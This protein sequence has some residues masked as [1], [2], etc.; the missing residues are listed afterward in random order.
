MRG[1]YQRLP[2][3]AGHL[4]AGPRLSP[5]MGGMSET[6]R[7]VLLAKPRGYCAGVDRA[8]QAVE[9][10]LTRF[11]APVYVR[12]QIVHNLHVVRSLEQ[13]GAV[14]VDE[15]ADVPPGS[16]V[17]FSA[18]G[19]APDVRV[20][21]EQRGLQ[22]GGVGDHA[23]AEGRGRPRHVGERG[24]DEPTGQRFRHGEGLAAFPQPVQD[25]ARQ[26]ACRLAC[27]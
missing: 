4:L 24:R 17:V 7:R 11:G 23:T 12:K 27:G 1:D 15:N 6:H 8:V 10:A 20:D 14:F 26:I 19:I 3:Q 13:R 22:F 2:M 18:H 21:A 5:T 25:L 9:I 16:V